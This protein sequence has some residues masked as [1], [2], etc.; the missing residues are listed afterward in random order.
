MVDAAAFRVGL[1][2]DDPVARDLVHSADMLIIVAKNF[3][4]FTD[5]AE[6]AAL[7]L[8]AFAPAAEIAFEL[9]LML[10][11]IILVIAVELTHLPIAPAAVM[12]I[13]LLVPRPV[14]PVGGAG[15]AGAAIV[16][17]A[18]WALRAVIIAHARLAA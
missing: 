17:T 11:P 12:R 4:M 6:Q 7:L 10:A 3:H 2:E 18:P 5:L 15:A 8:P 14:G 9:R 16:V 1:G 13:E